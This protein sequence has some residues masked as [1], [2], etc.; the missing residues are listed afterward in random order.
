MRYKRNFFIFIFYFL[1]AL[2]S[3]SNIVCSRGFTVCINSDQKVVSF[4]YITYCAREEVTYVFSPKK[5]KK[6]K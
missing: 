6:T 5:K 1:M 4:G 2:R 3:V